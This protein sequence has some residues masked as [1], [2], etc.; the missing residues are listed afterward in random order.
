MIL[1]FCDDFHHNMCNWYELVAYF[2]YLQLLVRWSVLV[3]GH[4][5]I[6]SLASSRFGFISTPF[7]T[8]FDPC[9]GRAGA[10]SILLLGQ[11]GSSGIIA[12]A[13]LEYTL[14]IFFEP[15]HL[16]YTFRIF[17]AGVMIMLA[18][19]EYTFR[20]S[21]SWYND[22][23]MVFWTKTTFPQSARHDHH[24]SSKKSCM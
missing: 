7:W 5:C 2:Y 4:C 11:Q 10:F 3:Y 20:I 19:L 15:A 14:Q 24:A 22:C 23:T 13:H 12:L 1:C 17:W 21:L 8:Y 18:H 16:E 6:A 9:D